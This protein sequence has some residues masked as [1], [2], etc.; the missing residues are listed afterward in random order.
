[1]VKWEKGHMWAMCPVEWSNSLK[2][3]KLGIT[4][5]R[6][7][8]I[9]RS[10]VLWFVQENARIAVSLWFV[11]ENARIAVSCNYHNPQPYELVGECWQ[12]ICTI[13]TTL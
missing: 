6:T 3:M 7:T 4:R 11:Q 13:N 1:M 10:C 8:V 9:R 12:G 5:K 2:G